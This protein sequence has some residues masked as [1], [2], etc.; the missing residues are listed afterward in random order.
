MVFDRKLG[1]LQKVCNDLS[2]EGG[3]VNC[4][5]KE[6]S[7][8]NDAVFDVN[9]ASLK[10]VCKKQFQKSCLGGS[11]QEISSTHDESVSMETNEVID[12]IMETELKNLKSKLQ[13]ITRKELECDTS[14]PEDFNHIFDINDEVNEVTFKVNGVKSNDCMKIKHDGKNLFLRR[15]KVLNLQWFKLFLNDFINHV[16]CFKH[17][18]P[19]FRCRTIGCS[20]TKYQRRCQQVF[21]K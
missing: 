14:K 19:Y 8:S 15:V 9:N 13:D 16:F 17:R 6:V 3:K 11:K 7:T 10:E 21:T 12:E 2:S 4:S 20:K 18:L 1:T 5:Q